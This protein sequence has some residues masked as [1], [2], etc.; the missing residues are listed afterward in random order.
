MTARRD[1]LGELAPRDSTG[2]SAGAEPSARGHDLWHA[3]VSKE[4]KEVRRLL[5]TKGMR[6]ELLCFPFSPRAGICRAEGKFVQPLPSH[7]IPG[8]VL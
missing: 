6:G 3:R 8:N 7:S 5:S 4:R 1:T 2:H